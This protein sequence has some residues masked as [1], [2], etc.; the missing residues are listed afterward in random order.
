MGLGR[1]QSLMTISFTEVLDLSLLGKKYTWYGSGNR[2]SRLDRCLVTSKWL[3]KFKDLCLKGLKR[4]LSDH[5]PLL[6]ATEKYDWGPKHF[7]TFDCWFNDK[8]LLSLIENEWNKMGVI[9]SAG[10]CIKVKLS[11]L[12]TFL[13]K[14]NAEMFGNVNVT[15]SNL[16]VELEG[17][18][19]VGDS[20][21]LD[22]IEIEKKKKIQEALWKAVKNK[23]EFWRQKSKEL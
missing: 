4:A 17:W 19:K 12:K 1:C 16:E 22:S 21:Q 6:L 7:K 8:I 2:K 23:E 18:D 10:Y 13:K 5:C 20:R 3:I 11:K 15:I 9:G 14:W